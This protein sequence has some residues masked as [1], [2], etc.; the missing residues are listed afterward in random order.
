V[1]LRWQ[2]YA[3]V[4]VRGCEC[5]VY[6][7]ARSIELGERQVMVGIDSTEAAEQAHVAIELY[8]IG[9]LN[10]LASIGLESGCLES[11]RRGFPAHFPPSFGQFALATG[12]RCGMRCPVRTELGGR[13]A[14]GQ[15]SVVFTAGSP[16]VDGN[17]N[18]EEGLMI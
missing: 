5:M 16:P 14:D 18:L 11:G 15:G 17:L 10:L 1:I 8:A 6:F 13:S 3:Y 12:C 2:F 9:A 7:F 4:A